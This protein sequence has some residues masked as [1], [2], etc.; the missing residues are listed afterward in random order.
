MA[1]IKKNIAVLILAAGSSSRMGRPKQLLPWKDTTLLGTILKKSKLSC[2]TEIVVV[3]GAYA[4]RIKSEI[5][6]DE[7]I[8]LVNK[9]WE[10]G[11][12]GSLAFGITHILENR[13]GLDGVLVLLGDQPF[14]DEDFIETMIKTFYENEK[15][16][17]ATSYGKKVGVPALFSRDYF[18]ELIG[19]EGD[20]GAKFLLQEYEDDIIPLTA[21]TVTLDIDTPQDY[22]QLKSRY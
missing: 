18:N 4:E 9:N 10:S 11:L 14:V 12:G 16:I 13:K 5:E 6:K 20:S 21:G 7:Y 17:V 22:E 19:L 8:L 15:G 1:D 3:L 2:P